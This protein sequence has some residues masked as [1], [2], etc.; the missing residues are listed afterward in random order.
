MGYWEPSL[1]IDGADEP[2]ALLLRV[3]SLHSLPQALVKLLNDD[4]IVFIGRGVGGDIAKINRDFGDAIITVN[5][6]RKLDLDFMLKSRGVT[7]GRQNTLEKI[8][9]LTVGVNM[10][11]NPEI[12]LSKWSAQELTADQQRYAAMDVI[13]PLRI[14][15]YLMK[16]PDLCKRFTLS[17]VHELIIRQT[18]VDIVPMHGSQSTLATRMATGN[19]VSDDNHWTPPSWCEKTPTQKSKFHLVLV[20]IT[21]IYAKSFVVPFYKKKGDKV[22]TLDDFGGAPFDLLVPLKALAPC[23]PVEDCAKFLDPNDTSSESV[24]AVRELQ[25]DARAGNNVMSDVV[26]KDPAAG[27]AGFLD[28]RDTSSESVVAVR[29]LQDDARSGNN[30]I[31]AVVVAKNPAAGTAG[32]VKH[33]SDV[34]NCSTLASASNVES[35]SDDIDWGHSSSDAFW[36][37]LEE[38]FT[39][40]AEETSWIRASTVAVDGTSFCVKTAHL[41][42]APTVIVDKFSSILGDSFHH[43]DRAKVPMHHSHKK[44]FFCTKL[45]MVCV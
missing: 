6:T 31:S 38:N 33:S 11:K 19:L 8:A 32:V 43:M 4:T 18:A 29:E 15:E 21:K 40:T 36:K 14:Y 44:A 39:L 24:V 26:A 42:V 41:R 16:K 7:C 10:V 25:D 20:R 27:T 45:S 13:V 5:K 34:L 22:V 3:H 35:T 9:E 30:V 2:R 1:S 28:P 12:R 17:E 37:S 23:Y